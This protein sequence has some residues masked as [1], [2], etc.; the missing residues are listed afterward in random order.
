ME[1]HPEEFYEEV[2]TKLGGPRWANLL[3][4]VVNSKLKGEPVSDTIYLNAAEIDALYEGYK[5]IRRK[6]FDDQVMRT[7]L[8]PDEKLSQESLKSIYGGTMITPYSVWGEH[9]AKLEQ[10]KAMGIL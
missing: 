9:Q 4:L 7:V 1:T 3:S 6:A 8:A 2:K 10:E 5:K